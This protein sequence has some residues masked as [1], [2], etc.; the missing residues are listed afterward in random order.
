[1]EN[2]VHDIWSDPIVRPKRANEP[3]KR[4]QEQDIM[5]T[6]SVMKP[7]GGESYNPSNQ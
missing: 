1:M 2:D 4:V 6:P 7:M 3:K 5:Q